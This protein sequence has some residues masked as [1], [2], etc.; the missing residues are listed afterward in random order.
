MVGVDAWKEKDIQNKCTDNL[1][2]LIDM[3]SA[4]KKNIATD[5]FTHDAANRPQ[6]NIFFVAHTENHLKTMKA[7]EEKTVKN[8]RFETLPKSMRFLYFWCAII[9]GNDIRGHHK[10]RSRCS[11]QSEVE[12]FQC[13]IWFHDDIAGFQILWRI[14][15]VKISFNKWPI[16]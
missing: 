14:K 3:I 10:I 6:V 13:A 8:L 12:N 9:S 5:H 4:R 16:I 11:C 7:K 2:P 1:V 15:N